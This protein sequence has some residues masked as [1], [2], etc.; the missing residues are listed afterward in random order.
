MVAA[1]EKRDQLLEDLLALHLALAH[2]YQ[3]L[4]D[5]RRD[6]APRVWDQPLL[7]HG[8]DVRVEDPVALLHSK[9]LLVGDVG[10]DVVQRALE[11]A[12]EDDPY[13][14][15]QDL[16][17]AIEAHAHT[18]ALLGDLA[19]GPQRLLIR[20]VA[21]SRDDGRDDGGGAALLDELA[22]HAG[23]PV[24]VALVRRCVSDED[25][26]AVGTSAT[27]SSC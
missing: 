25:D 27:T 17:L 1:H 6:L 24:A 21:R 16:L 9:A 11:L 23:D 19:K 13:D 15:A 14:L 8:V 7:D 20:V 26:E 3:G 12:A 4:D 18:L 5:L 22:D 2:V 10:A